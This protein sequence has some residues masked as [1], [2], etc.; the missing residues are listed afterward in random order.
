M[1]QLVLYSSY[2]V[3]MWVFGQLRTGLVIVMHVSTIIIYQYQ[4]S[5]Q[6]R[7]QQIDIRLENES[8]VG[9]SIRQ[10]LLH[11]NAENCN[12]ILLQIFPLPWIFSVS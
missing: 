1:T 4:G 2:E 3:K 10:N 12:Q 11:S 9:T 8:R 5:P 7:L 6:Q